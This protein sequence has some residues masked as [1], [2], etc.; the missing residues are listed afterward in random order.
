MR[1]LLNSS[2]E[3]KPAEAQPAPTAGRMPDD[4]IENGLVHVVD[5]GDGLDQVD[6]GGGFAQA[7]GIH[8]GFDHA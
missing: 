8:V 4:H 2:T 6:D 7:G 3:P 5:P 1:F